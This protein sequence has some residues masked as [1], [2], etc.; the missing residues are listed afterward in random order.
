MIMTIHSNEEIQEEPSALEQM[1]KDIQKI[2]E[3]LDRLE[4]LGVA[5]DILEI[6]ISHKTKLG[7]YKVK[8][9]LEAQREFLREAIKKK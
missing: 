9:V 5:S 4:K 7:R 6:Y 3:A 8:S 1:V 2:R